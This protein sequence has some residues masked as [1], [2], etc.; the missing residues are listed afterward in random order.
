[1][2]NCSLK[3]SPVNEFPKSPKTIRVLTDSGTILTFRSPKLVREVTHDFRGYGI[4]KRGQPSTP[5]DGHESL[6]TSQF[7]YLLPLLND[8]D[9]SP[10]Q[11]KETVEAGEVQ[12]E[13]VGS[14]SSLASS[15]GLEV[16][17]H[18]GKGVW[19]VKLVIGT[20][21]LEQIL[22]E[23]VNVEA[24]VERMREAA[25]AAAATAGSKPSP[26]SGRA[27]QLGKMN[28]FNVFDRVS[29]HC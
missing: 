8:T 19:K 23:E 5:L 24:L 25:A 29:S 14:S 9:N 21:E 7:Y 28:R 3:G 12:L 26:K 11:I 13:T 4:F 2:G 20:K 22:A 6:L 17:R 15:A 18:N 1:M 27:S 10:E 16:V